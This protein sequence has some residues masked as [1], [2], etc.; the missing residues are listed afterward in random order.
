MPL[1]CARAVLYGKADM[2]PLPRPVAEVCAV[3]QNATSQPGETLD[4]IGEYCYRGLDHDAPAR[5]AAS[6]AMPLRPCC[7]AAR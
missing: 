5:R 3:A 6:K 2:V 7:R 1:T 4:A